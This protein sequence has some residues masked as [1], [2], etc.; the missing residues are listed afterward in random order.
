MFLNSPLFHLFYTC[1]E[2]LSLLCLFLKDERLNQGAKLID[3]F[4]KLFH[5]PS[6]ANEK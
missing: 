2:S 5:D 3:I 4:S 6:S 1:H